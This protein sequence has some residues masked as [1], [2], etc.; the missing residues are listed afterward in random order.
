MLEVVGKVLARIIQDRLQKVVEDEVLESQCGFRKGRGCVDMIFVVRQ[1]AE[2]VVEHSTKHFILI[3]DL[4]KVYD[5]VPRKALWIVLEKYGVPEK[6]INLIRSF[7]DGMMS[8]VLVNGSV[9]EELEVNNGLRQGCTLAPTLFNLFIN[10]VMKQF[11]NDCPEAG[12]ILLYRNANTKLVG[13]RRK[14]D[15]REKLVE[16]QFA[17][18]AAI[19][20]EN[21]RVLE[22]AVKVLMIVVAKWGL[23]VNIVKTKA[24]VL[25]HGVAEDYKPVK[26]NDGDIEIVEN[27]KYL[28]STINSMGE[29]SHDIK[30]RVA[31]ASRA[32]GI[33]R[34]AVFNDKDLHVKTKA[35]VYSAVVLSTLL[36]G[37]ET[38]TTKQIDIQKLESFNNRCLRSI[39][40]INRLEQWKQHLSTQQ[41]RLDVGFE[42]SMEELVMKRRLRWL[43][44][45]ARMPANRLPKK[46]LYGELAEK[47]P[48]HGP[49][50]RWR[51]RVKG[52]LKVTGIDVDN[53]FD[54]A[55]DRG[56]WRCEC[57]DG[58]QKFRQIKLVKEAKRQ[59][60][61]ERRVIQI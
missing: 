19:V 13:S 50:I 6:V 48:Q 43:G 51:D 34:K 20:T 18:D 47:R 5:S 3:I 56:E 38:W 15:G 17:D 46:V 53:W 59:R 7:H 22:H 30:D 10:F 37:S 61:K 12:T 24:M 58:L 33:L 35:K 55:Q 26:T 45:I 40:G 39:K 2:K 21:R 32:F 28:G 8:K 23:H 49:K 27:F 31:N 60:H 29:V 57:A 54:M 42:S 25:G 4:Q 9:T 11:R 41:I 1:L 14:I 52:D 44:H 36:Y 16:T